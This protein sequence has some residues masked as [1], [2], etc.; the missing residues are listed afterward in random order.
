M[1][2]T[3]ITIIKFTVAL[4]ALWYVL[5]HI[6]TTQLLHHIQA[7]DSVWLILAGATLILSQLV[8][9][10]RLRYYLYTE[11]LALTSYQAISLYWL[12]ALFNLI[13]PGGIGGDGYKTLLLKQQYN[14][15]TITAL[16]RVLSERASGLLALCIIALLTAYLSKISQLIPYSYVVITTALVAVWPC[17][18][19]A[20]KML[21][22]ESKEQA[23]GALPYSMI[24]QLLSVLTAYILFLGVNI[25]LYLI[26]YLLLFLISSII[27]V[28]PISIGGMGLREITFYYGTQLLNLPPEQGIAFSLVYFAINTGV[29][30]LGVYAWLRSK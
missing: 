18:Y 22:K 1:K 30:M 19:I 26:D 25:E 11:K 28:L 2:K 24:V 14:M 6:D 21:L 23:L 16:Q 13:L 4:V 17:Y 29:S 20:V 27:S 7:I 3:A 5:Q 15:K 12:G 10:Y 8:S 9:A